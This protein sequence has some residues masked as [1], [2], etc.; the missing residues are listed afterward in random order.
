[1]EVIL[2]T[3]GQG[4]GRLIQEVADLFYHILVLLSSRGLSLG[5]VEAELRHRH[6]AKVTNDE[7]IPL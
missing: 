7:D 2:A 1:M 5:E 3:K 4:D 6:A